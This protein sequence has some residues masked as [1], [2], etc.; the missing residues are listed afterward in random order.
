M[1]VNYDIHWN[2]VRLIQRFGRIDRIGSPCEE[3]KSVNFWPAKS[4]EDY[5]NLEN[6]IMNRMAIMNLTGAETQEVND[7]YVQMVS[8]NTLQDKNAQRLLK[9]LTENSISDIE[10][11]QAL[12]LKDFSLETYRQDLLEYF[13]K[14]K[15]FFRNM[16]CGVYSGFKADDNLFNSIPESIIAVLGYPHREEGSK[17]QYQNIY[18]VCQPV[19]NSSRGTFKELNQAEILEFLRRNKGRERYVPDWIESTDPVKISKLSNVLKNWT[20]S[21][22]KEEGRNLLEDLFSTQKT[23]AEKPSLSANLSQKFKMENFDLIVWDYIS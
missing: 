21:K 4:F 13:E 19:D 18:L 3:I 16:P 7:R 6:R 17:K 8:D 15:D 10:S 9:E 20:Q 2:P 1:Q 5:L 14:H 22:F 12:S 23:V 11:D